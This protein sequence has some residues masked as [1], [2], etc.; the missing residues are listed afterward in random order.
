MRPKLVAGMG[1]EPII[2]ELMRLAWLSVPLARNNLGRGPRSRTGTYLRPRQVAYH[3]PRPR[4]LWSGY[5]ESNRGHMLP[6][7]ELVLPAIA[8][9]L[10]AGDRNRTASSVWKTEALPLSYTRVERPAVIETASAPWQSAILP[11]NYGRSNLVETRGVEPPL[12]VCRTSV[13]P[14]SLRPQIWCPVRLGIP[15]PPACRAGAHNPSELTGQILVRATRL[16][17]ARRGLR[18]RYSATRIP[19]AWSRRRESN[20]GFVLTGDALFH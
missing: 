14:L 9:N 4:K 16:E 10:G 1:V 20:A 19:P 12:L 17:L 5:S 18:G 3:W 6:K 8:R 2:F 7:H 15:G 13:L 11:L